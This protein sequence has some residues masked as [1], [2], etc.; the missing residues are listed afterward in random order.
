MSFDHGLP[1]YVLITLNR[2]DVSLICIQGHHCYISTRF[3]TT[4]MVL[5]TKD[6]SKYY[7]KNVGKSTQ[8]FVDLAESDF[9]AIT[10]ILQ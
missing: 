3:K 8:V 7:P 6:D 2:E 1:L 4:E 10:D 9:H 5:I